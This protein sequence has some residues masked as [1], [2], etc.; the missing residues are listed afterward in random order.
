ML[1]DA[2]ISYN[3][4]YLSLLTS[5]YNENKGGEEKC[6]EEKGVDVHSEIYSM[7]GV[8]DNAFPTTSF[9]SR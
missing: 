1:R 9:Y 5:D 2:Q 4:I 7:T 3:S 8:S 6:S